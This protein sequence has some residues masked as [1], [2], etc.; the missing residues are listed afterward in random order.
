[1][2]LLIILLVGDASLS[3]ACKTKSSPVK[4]V[5]SGLFVQAGKVGVKALRS[6]C[7]DSVFIAGAKCIIQ[8]LTLRIAGIFVASLRLGSSSPNDL[9]EDFIFFSYRI[10]EIEERTNSWHGSANL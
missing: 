9:L 6:P 8:F 3:Y 7:P 10:P 5:F 1:V 4:S 2:K